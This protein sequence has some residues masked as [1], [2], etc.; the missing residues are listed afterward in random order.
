MMSVKMPS[1]RNGPGT[2]SGVGVLP[3]MMTVVINIGATVVATEFKACDRVM[4]KAPLS[5]L[6]STITYGL[7]TFCSITTP[8]AT[9][10][11]ES[12]KTT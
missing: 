7:A 9:I 5:G 11:I 8:M 1:P 10:H 4:R 2:A 3:A 6:P 12:R